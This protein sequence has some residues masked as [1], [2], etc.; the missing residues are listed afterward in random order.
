M[1][2]TD[3]RKELIQQIK[4]A[5]ADIKAWMARLNQLGDSELKVCECAWCVCGDCCVCN[6]L[7]I[8]QTRIV[9]ARPPI[10]VCK[11]TVCV[12]GGVCM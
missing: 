3:E 9:T 4:K 2:N 5:R 1:N 6:G 11:C 12:C 10:C 7:L 8:N